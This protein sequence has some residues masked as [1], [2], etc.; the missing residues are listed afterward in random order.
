MRLG[1][2]LLVVLG[3]ALVTG[4]WGD[5]ASWLQQLLTGSDSFRPVV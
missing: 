3:L 4:V 5:W 2:A 1:G